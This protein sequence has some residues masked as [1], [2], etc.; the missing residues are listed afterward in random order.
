MEERTIIEK[1]KRVRVANGITQ[2]D[3]AERM[4]IVQ[5]AVSRIESGTHSPSVD[6]LEK[7]A[8][9]VGCRLEI[10]IK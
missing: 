10:V 3:V 8:D 4:G 9:A 2:H 5:A 1:L 7:Y 6:M